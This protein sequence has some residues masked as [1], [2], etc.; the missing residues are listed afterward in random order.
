MQ[1]VIL[2]VATWILLFFAVPAM[3]DGIFAQSC[4]CANWTCEFFTNPDTG[5]TSQNCWCQT[6][7]GA[8][9]VG[10]PAG[11]YVCN[12]GCCPV[13]TGK[14]EK[15]EPTCELEKY[16]EMTWVEYKETCEWVTEWKQGRAVSRQVCSGGGGEWIPQ[17]KVRCKTAPV[18][19]PSCG[20]PLCG[21]S[22][23]CG[24]SC[25][26]TDVNTWG[27]WSACSATCGGGTQSRTNA[28]GTLQS[29]GCNTQSCPGPWWQVK[30]GSV[31]SASGI[32][33][34]IPG[35]CAGG[36]TPSLLTGVSGLAS[37]LGTLGVGGGSLSQDGTNWQAETVY[38]GT[39]TGFGYFKRLLE[40]DPAGI[41]VW[42]GGLPAQDGVFLAEGSVLRVNP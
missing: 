9:G 39:R 14:K 33:S 38:A 24:G 18:C 3:Q 30:D 8:C 12:T 16:S 41:G 5:G 13:G 1:R 29:Q 32:F 31:H 2:F 15:E 17:D 34:N 11:F 23:G 7:T 20:S 28:C 37:Y 40:D 27:A 4:Q 35:A 6:D 42:D 19:T 26:T 21:Q 22:N 10:C 36:C 25:A